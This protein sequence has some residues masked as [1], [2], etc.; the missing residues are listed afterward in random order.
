M[1]SL[2]RWFYRALTPGFPL[3]VHGCLLARLVPFGFMDAQVVLDF[4]VVFSRDFQLSLP[5]RGV[6]R[7]VELSL[8]GSSPVLLVMRWENTRIFFQRQVNVSLATYGIVAI[9]ET[10]LI[11]QR[12]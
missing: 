11:L 5:V 1:L 12:G 2:I 8:F 6:M 3:I 4:K 10:I 9:V 7:S